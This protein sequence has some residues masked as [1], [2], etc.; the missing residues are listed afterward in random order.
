MRCCL[1]RPAAG[2]SSLSPLRGPPCRQGGR[3]AHGG[4]KGVSYNGGPR[5]ASPRPRRSSP[6]SCSVPDRERRDARPG[7]PGPVP[8]RVRPGS[9]RGAEP[10][11]AASPGAPRR[12]SIRCRHR[13]PLPPERSPEV[14]PCSR[15]R[16]HRPPDRPYGCR[17]GRL[18]PRG[19]SPPHARLRPGA[20]A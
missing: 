13:L 5:N 15:A 16:R 8:A 4:T 12:V 14:P 7:L 2:P 1:L 6:D 10:K 3:P 18:R 17:S 9:R 20:P 11:D 19:R